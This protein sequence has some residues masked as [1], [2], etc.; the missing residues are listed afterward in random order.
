[1]SPR[2]LVAS[3]AVLLLASCARPA[4]VPKSS[5]SIAVSRDDA[6]LFVADADHDRLTVIDTATRAVLRQTPLAKGPERVLVAPDGAIFVS[7]RGARTVS[8]LTADGAGVEATATVGAEPVGLALSSDLTQL[9]V[10]NSM[11]GTISVLDAA[12]LEPRREVT[13]GG[14][15]WAVTAAADGR[16]LYVTDFL[17][18]GVGVL[19]LERNVLSTLTL[20]QP[21]VAECAFGEVPERT[22]AQPA[23]VV[24]SP[25]GDR[26]YVAHV[27]SR[28][29]VTQGFNVSLRLAVAPAMSTIDTDTDAVFQDVA[30]TTN[31]LTGE[32]VTTPPPYPPA[33]LGTNLDESCREAGAGTGMDAP[34][35]LV[36]D[37]L[38]Q[39]IFVADHNSNAV[40]IV[41][42]MG[43]S[44]PDYRVPERGI[45]DVVRVGA[46]PTGIAVSGDLRRAWVHNA[47]DYTVSVI[48]NRSGRLVES[49]VI[50]FDRSPL[51]AEVDQGRRLFYSAVDPRLTQ[52]EFGGV[53]CSSCHPDGRTDGLSWVLPEGATSTGPWEAPGNRPS[54]NTP[55]L[56]G[57]TGTAPYHWDGALAD[58]P[59]FSARMVSQ[60]GGFGLDAREVNQLSSYLATVKPPDNPAEGLLAPGLVARGEALFGARCGACHAGE[61]LTDGRAHAALGSGQKLDTPSLRGVFATAPYLH[62]G[63][64]STL[65]GVL[66]DSRPTIAAHAQ[67]GLSASDL[68]ALEAFLRTK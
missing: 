28:T 67:A 27:Q 26:V 46:R 41:S 14:Q 65:R 39:W 9:F 12:T 47:L 57:V 24:L 63:S 31:P 19:D 18:G 34:S 11:S 50:A 64:R 21:S 35:S 62:D 55:A 51:P 23:D 60:M 48:E 38:G 43:R 1:M 32:V 61:A 49:E 10:A 37:G 16:R 13:V 59:A 20:E 7:S 66:V 68:D 29:G 30:R 25:E 58:L 4:V 53:S 22:P 44:A 40:A 15:P 45:A 8:K 5:G 6:L 36:V 42:A 56:W 2:H 33:L 54:R 52:P 17:A 3:L